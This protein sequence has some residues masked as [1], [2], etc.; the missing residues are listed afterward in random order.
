MKYVATF[1]LAVL[2]SPL[3]MIAGE[4]DVKNLP[5]IIEKIDKSCVLIASGSGDIRGSGV[6]VI[7]DKDVYVITCFHLIYPEER[8][9]FKIWNMEFEKFYNFT[10]YKQFL[11]KN[12]EINKEVF[13]KAKVFAYDE[14]LDLVIFKL[15]S[16]PDIFGNTEFYLEDNI[17]PRGTKII[18]VA[19]FLEY[20]ST[21]GLTSSATGTIGEINRK[22]E[23]GRTVNGVRQKA[24]RPSDLSYDISVGKGCSGSGM[25]NEYGKY[26]GMTYGKYSS[27]I[28]IY[29]P[30]RE[31]IKWSSKN[32]T[33][34]IFNNSEKYP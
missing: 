16:P 12:Y 29:T 27:N 3:F 1:L 28:A 22:V 31:L 5:D 10:I 13:V 8:V 9:R 18:A 19:N 4:N 30:I 7:R 15:E 32:N 11:D 24:Y 26:I 21:P 33:K 14:I 34:W 17:L 23:L 6:S 20:E 25:F 2:I